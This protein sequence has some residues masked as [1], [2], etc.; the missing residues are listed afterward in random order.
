MA[1]IQ[2]DDAPSQNGTDEAS[3]FSEQEQ[4]ILYMYDQVQRLEL[5]VALIKASVK[6]AGTLFSRLLLTH[7]S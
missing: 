1:D 3:P 2:M 7:P 5:E 6:L 4:E